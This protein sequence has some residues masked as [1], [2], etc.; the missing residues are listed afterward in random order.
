MRT[1]GNTIFVYGV[2]RILKTGPCVQRNICFLEMSV[3]T[4]GVTGKKRLI[5]SYGIKS[6]I[7]EKGF[8]IDQRMPGKKSFSVGI[9]SFES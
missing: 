1:T 8:G 9:K 5:K 4:K 6:S 3:F 2:V 7:T